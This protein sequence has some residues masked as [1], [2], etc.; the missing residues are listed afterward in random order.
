M[1]SETD[2]ANPVGKALWYIESHFADELSLEDVAAIAGVTRYHLTRAFGEATGHSIMRYMRGRRLSEA[3][4]SLAHGAPDILAVALDAGYGSHEA[5]TRAFRDQFGR[6]PEAVRAQRQLDDVELV[7]AIRMDQSLL[8]S[9]KPVRIETTKPL[10]IAGLGERNTCET[11]ARIPSQWQRFAPSIATMPKRTSQVG[12]GVRYNFDE[13]GNFDYVCGV[14][15]TDF[16]DLGLEFARVR[17]PAHRYAVFEH[18]GHVS[19]IRRTHN[20]IWNNWLPASTFEPADTPDFERYDERFD[21]VTGNG[22]VEI[23]VAISDRTT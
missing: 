7:E 15:V 11:S 10:L 19:T 9:I 13:A 20:T 5:F 14:E 16:S 23:W 4:R 18:R 2:R 3:A 17:I 6:T 21:P 22:V 8:D 12:Y 1:P